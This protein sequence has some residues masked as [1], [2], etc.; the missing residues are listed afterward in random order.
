MVVKLIEAN[1]SVMLV[2]DN[3]KS[4]YLSEKEYVVSELGQASV[5]NV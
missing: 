3:W 4:P 2:K 1:T 5:V